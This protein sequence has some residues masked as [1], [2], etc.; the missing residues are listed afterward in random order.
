MDNFKLT[1][2]YITSEYTSE[3]SLSHHL[4]QEDALE[5]ADDLAFSTV[6]FPL[7]DW[8]FFDF[9]DQNGFYIFY[10]NAEDKFSRYKLTILKEE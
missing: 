7:E 2:S 8:E 9:G 4:T 3:E 10:P 5:E 6:G 1:L